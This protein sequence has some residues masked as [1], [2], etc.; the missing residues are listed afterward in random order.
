MHHAVDLVQEVAGVV[1]VVTDLQ[2]AP[3]ARRRRRPTGACAA[4]RRSPSSISAARPSGSAQARPS[5]LG[6]GLVQ[7]WSRSRD[8]RR[9]RDRI[10]E[11]AVH[12]SCVLGKRHPSLHPRLGST[13]ISEEPS[14][15]S[16]AVEPRRETVLRLRHDS[17]RT[18][19][20]P[21]TGRVGVSRACSASIVRADSALGL[22]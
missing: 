21:Y 3:G 6:P 18:V 12:R 9:A 13:S 1:G 10:G 4:V 11:L 5:D 8:L 19:R 7:A 22:R 15:A 16:P 20:P 2:L 14:A 17:R